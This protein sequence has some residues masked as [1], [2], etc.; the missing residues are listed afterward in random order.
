MSSDIQSV[1]AQ[2][3]QTEYASL[4]LVVAIGYDYCLTFSKEVTYIWVCNRTS[5]QVRTPYMIP[6][7]AKPLD[8]GVYAL[9]SLVMILRVYAIY[10][11]SRIILGVLLVMYIP[12]VVMIIVSSGIY[13]DPNYVA[14]S[15]AQLLDI[16]LC[17]VVLSTQTW[18][19]ATRIIQ[20]ILGTVMC[21]LV[22]AQ[23]VKQSLQMYQATRKW[24]LNRYMNLLV[25][26]SLLYFLATLLYGIVNMLGLL[27][28]I[29]QGWFTSLLAVAVDVLLYTLTPRFV[30][31]IREMYVRDTQGRGNHDIDTGFGLPSGAGR[32][33]GGS[34]TIG[35]IAF[36]NGVGSEGL[37]NGREIA[38]AEE[39]AENNAGWQV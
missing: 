9:S 34:T 11:R 15:I 13:S 35:T 39:R 6:I 19:T 21:I 22:T 7:M 8:M 17:N 26:D 29:P 10:N 5:L 4:V 12:E 31:N 30:M 23:F 24:Q 20:F 14:V 3:Q 27:G 36:A 1:L 25:R 16:T 33:V 18:S 38:T 2:I 37:G 28:N 32:G